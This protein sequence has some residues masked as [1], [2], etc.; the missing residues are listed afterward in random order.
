MIRC[1]FLSRQISRAEA[2]LE[3]NNFSFLWIILRTVGD[4]E[5]KFK[6][7]VHCPFTFVK[8]QN[9]IVQNV[10]AFENRDFEND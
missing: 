4:G 10:Q 9:T 5:N 8:L 3:R 7:N 1:K 6:R 2:D